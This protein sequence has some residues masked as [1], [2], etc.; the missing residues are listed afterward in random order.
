M[1]LKKLLV[2]FCILIGFQSCIISNPTPEDCVVV[3]KTI[4]KVVEGSSYDIVFRTPDGD[5]FYINR[6]LEQGLVIADLEDQVLGKE[7][8]L[9]LAKVMAGAVTTDHISQLQVDETILY[10]EFD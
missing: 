1:E 10:T 3:S 8:I 9:H 2:I 6:G 7:V 4:S 5:Y